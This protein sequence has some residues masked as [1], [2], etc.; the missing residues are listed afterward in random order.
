VNERRMRGGPYIEFGS[1]AT[2]LRATCEL[3]W[4]ELAI[5]MIMYNIDCDISSLI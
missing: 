4:I 1:V 3:E 2:V 5:L